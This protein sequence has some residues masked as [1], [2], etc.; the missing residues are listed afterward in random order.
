MN[1]IDPVLIHT[2]NDEADVFHY[3]LFFFLWKM[4]QKS[5]HQSAD[6]IIFV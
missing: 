6:G 2:F 3:N 1:L 5:D 4:V